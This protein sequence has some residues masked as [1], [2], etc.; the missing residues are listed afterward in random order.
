MQRDLDILFDKNNRYLDDPHNE[1]GN[2]LD[3]PEH[4]AGSVNMPKDVHY[5]YEDLFRTVESVKDKVPTSLAV[6]LE[7]FTDTLKGTL[8]AMKLVD[9][10]DPKDFH[11]KLGE[12]LEKNMLKLQELVHESEIKHREEMIKDLEAKKGA[13]RRAEILKRIKHHEERIK[14]HRAQI[15]RLKKLL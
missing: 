7:E 9:W 6:K 12:T 2:Y 1:T 5:A 15:I 8:A 11:E 13:A 10:A 14:Y 4:E 3:A